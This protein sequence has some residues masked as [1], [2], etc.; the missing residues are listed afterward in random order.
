MNTVVCFMSAGPGRVTGGR[1]CYAAPAGGPPDKY[2]RGG[3]RA[4]ASQ[5]P[6]GG[7]IMVSLRP[8][9]RGLFFSKENSH[10][11]RGKRSGRI[12]S[13]LSGHRPKATRMNLDSAGKGWL[14]AV[15]LTLGPSC[16]GGGKAA[17]DSPRL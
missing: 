16:A 3:S 9:P 12:V 17:M 14:M 5:P 8:P 6:D 13:S 10:R 11:Y 15:R 4:A 7:A 2:F 1:R